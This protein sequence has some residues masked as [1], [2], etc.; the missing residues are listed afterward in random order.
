[1]CSDIMAYMPTRFVSDR[2]PR[3]IQISGKNSLIQCK[4]SC[5]MSSA[6][7]Q[8]LDGQT[9]IVNKVL[10]YLRL[11]GLKIRDD[12]DKL[13]LFAELHITTPFTES[14]G[15]TPFRLNSGFDQF[16]FKF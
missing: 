4:V 16:T 7:H 2:D 12:W 8:K 14:T 6:F 1:M 11:C 13:L 5:K 15:S 10:S 3:L 9:E